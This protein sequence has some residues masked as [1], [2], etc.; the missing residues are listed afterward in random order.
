MYLLKISRVTAK[1]I[2]VVCLVILI[3]MGARWIQY[4]SE[5]YVC[6]HMARDI[7]DTLEPFGFDVVCVVGKDRPLGPDGV[8]GGNRS[9][10]MWVE[11]NGITIDSVYL[12]P[13]YPGINEYSYNITRYDDY[14]EYLNAKGVTDEEDRGN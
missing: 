13:F 6:R 14:Q 10:H 7:E 1:T 3:L 2:Y 11:I 9:G 12:L 8:D 4:S 5:V